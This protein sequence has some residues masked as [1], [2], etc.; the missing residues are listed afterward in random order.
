MAESIATNIAETERI[1][2]SR[3]SGDIPRIAIVLGSGLGRL[4]NDMDIECAISYDVLPAFPGTT[5]AGHAGQLIFGRYKDVS[6]VCM[7]GRMHYYEGHHSSAISSPIRVLRRL[8]VEILIL[9]NAAGSLRTDLPPG[10]LMIIE[11][12]INFSGFNP[13]IGANDEAIGPR[14]VDLTNAWDSDLRQLLLDSARDEGVAVD[15]GV[16]IQTSGPNFESPAEIRMFQT[17]GASAVGM[18][19]IPE[20]LVAHHCGMKVA[21]ISVITNLGA[22]IA[23]QPLSHTETIEVAGQAYDSMRAVVGRFLMNVQRQAGVQPSR[24]D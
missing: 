23:N 20:C 10:S 13:L 6:I 11:D 24:N 5:V 17:F 1:V 2:R 8:G 16:Y 19:T 4:G 18:S 9:T 3:F 15:K 14:F 21:G 22:G 7:Q 12:H